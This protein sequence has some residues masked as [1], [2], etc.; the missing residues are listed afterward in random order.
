MVSHQWGWCFLL[1][2]VLVVVPSQ[3]VILGDLEV[4]LVDGVT[5]DLGRLQVRR[6]ATDAWGNVCRESFDDRDATVACRS[7][8]STFQWGR[9]MNMGVGGSSYPRSERIS[10]ASVSCVGTEANLGRCNTGRWRSLPA[11]CSTRY[12]AVHVRC[13]QYTARLKPQFGGYKGAIYGA[14]ELMRMGNNYGSYWYTLCDSSW[15][16][17]KARD[18]CRLAGFVD[19]KA[20]TAGQLSRGAVDSLQRTVSNLNCPDSATTANA[21]TFTTV[22]DTYCPTRGNMASAIC[23]SQASHMVGTGFAIRLTTGSPSLW[24]RVEV[25]HLGMWGTVCSNDDTVASVACR[26]VTG[27]GGGVVLGSTYGTDFKGSSW[28]SN[29]SCSGQESSL[30][31]CVVQPWGAPTSCRPMFSLCYQS[32]APTVELVGSSDGSYGRVEIVMDGSRYTVCGDHWTTAEASVVC[33]SKGYAG[34]VALKSSYY[35]KGSGLVALNNV[36]CNGSEDSLLQCHHNGWLKS[37]DRCDTHDKDVSVYCHGPVVLRGGDHSN[38][39]V[40]VMVGDSYRT[41]CG[42]NFQDTEAGVVCRQMGFE[43]GRKLPAGSYGPFTSRLPPQTLDC[44]GDENSAYNCSLTEQACASTGNT[45]YAAVHCY[46][47]T[48]PTA[49]T[50]SVSG[51]IGDLVNSSGNVRVQLAGVKGR[52]CSMFWGDEDARVMCRQLGFSKGLAYGLTTSSVGPF[53]LTEVN[54]V[55]TESS[56]WDC[57]MGNASCTSDSQASVLCFND[58]PQV[59]LVGGSSKEGRVEITYQGTTGTVCTQPGVYYQQAASVVCRTLGYAWGFPKSFGSGEGKVML[60]YPSCSGTESNLLGCRNL[61]FMAPPVEHCSDHKHDMGVHCRGEV[62]LSHV[63]QRTNTSMAGQIRLHRNGR[64]YFVCQT[65]FQEEE[66]AVVCSQ[67]GY[68]HY[69]SVPQGPL[70]AHTLSHS[71]QVRP[72][73]TGREQSLASCPMTFG[74]CYPTT[75]R[76]NVYANVHCSNEPIVTGVVAVHPTSQPGEV[77]VQVD[78]LQSKVCSQNW[79][80]NAAKLYCSALGYNFGKAMGALSGYNIF[81]LLSRISC[82]GKTSF[83][84]CYPTRNVSCDVFHKNARVYCYNDRTDFQIR[85]VGGAV[86]SEGIVEIGL[87][88]QWGSVC[89]SIIRYDWW[90][91]SRATN[92]ANIV[93]R[94]LGFVGGDAIR[95]STN[96]VDPVPTFIWLPRCTGRESDIRGCKL[97]AFNNTR[98]TNI[99]GCASRPV[100]VRCLG[101]VKLEPNATYGAVHMAVNISSSTF[102]LV[103][104]DGFGDEEATVTCRDL[105]LPYG[106]HLSASAFGPLSSPAIRRTNLQCSGREPELKDCNYG[107]SIHYCPSQKYASVVC[108]KSS[109]N[110]GYRV[111]VGTASNS[112]YGRVR[113]QHMDHWGSVCPDN[114]TAGDAAVICREAGFAGGLAYNYSSGW[115][116]GNSSG[117]HWLK[118]VGCMGQES[119]LTRC[120]RVQW[121]NITGCTFTNDAAVFCYQHVAPYFHLANGTRSGAGRLMVWTERGYGSVCGRTWTDREASVACRSLGFHGGR[122]LGHG[123]FGKATGDVLIPESSCSGDESSL[124]G[125]SLR[126]KGQHVQDTACLSHDYDAS[127]Q[128]YDKIQISGSR[129][130]RYGGVE[131]WSGASLGWVAVC[132]EGFDTNA[133]QV[134]CRALGYSQGRRQCCSALGPLTSPRNSMTATHIGAKVNRCSGSESTLTKCDI[135]FSNS[136]CSSGKYASVLCSDDSVEEIRLQVRPNWFGRIYSY[137]ARIEVNRYGVWGPVCNHGWDDRDANATCHGLGFNYGRSMFLAY[138]TYEPMLVGNF[139]CTGLESSLADCSFGGMDDDIGCFPSH[140]TVLIAEALCFNVS[141]DSSLR[142]EGGGRQYGRLEVQFQGLWGAVVVDLLHYY[143]QQNMHV[144]CKQ[145]GFQDGMSI[146]TQRHSPRI[147]SNITRT[148]MDLVGCNGTEKTLFDCWWNTRIDLSLF[149]PIN[150]VCYNNVRL[151]GGN[152]VSTGRVEVQVNNKWGTVCDSQW[153]DTN[154]RLTCRNMGF[155]DGIQ[156]CCGVYG[157]GSRPVLDSVQ[158]GNA[159]TN[160]TA[161]QH[162]RVGHF[163]C[164]DNTVAVSCFNGPRP[165]E[166]SYSIK[167]PSEVVINF[168]GLDGHICSDGWDD[169]DA[170]VLC[171]ELGYP[172]ALRHEHSA[173]NKP[174]WATNVNCQGNERRLQDCQMNLGRVTECRSGKW[175][176][177]LCT[178]SEG[179]YYQLGGSNTEGRGR[180]EVSIN[181]EW[182]SLCHSGFGSNEATVLCHSQGYRE[183]QVYTPPGGSYSNAPSTVYGTRQMMCSGDEASLDDCHHG[184]WRKYNSCKTEDVARVR[185]YNDVRIGGTYDHTFA[186]GAVQFYHNSTWYNLCDTGFDDTTARRVCQDLNFFDGVA[187]CCSGYGSTHY[188]TSAISTH[189]NYSMQCNGEEQSSAQCIKPGNCT[190]DM[191]ASVLCFGP[192]DYLDDSSECFFVFSLEDYMDEGTYTFALDSDK[193]YGVVAVTHMNIVGRVCNTDWDDTDA[194][195]FCKSRGYRGGIASHVSQQSYSTMVS[196]GPFWVSGFNC[197]GKEASLNECPFNDRRHLGNCSTADVA[198]ALCFITKSIQYRIASNGLKANEGRVEVSVAG[199]WGTVCSYYWDDQDARVFCRSQGYTDGFR[200][201]LPMNMG[202]GPMWLSNIRCKGTESSL[203]ECPHD[204]YRS[205]PVGI[206]HHK[207]CSTHTYDA[208]VHCVNKLKLSLRYTAGMGAVMVYRDNAWTL[209]CD[210]GLDHAA[211]QV[212]CKQLGFPFGTNLS[213]AKFGKVQNAS[214]SVSKVACRGTESDFST[215]TFDVTSGCSSGKYASVVCS[216][217]AQVEQRDNVRFVRDDSEDASHGYLEYQ[218]QGVWGAVCA[219]TMDP[220]AASVACRQLGY[221]GGVPYTPNLKNVRGT[222]HLQQPILTSNLK[223]NGTESRLDQCARASVPASASCDFNST[224]AGVLCYNDT[225]GVSYRLTGEETLKTRGRVEMKMNGQYSVVCTFYGNN[226][227]ARVACKSLGYKDG[228]AVPGARYLPDLSAP[229][230]LSKVTCQGNERSILECNSAGFNIHVYRDYTWYMCFHRTG[231]LSVQCYQD[232]VAITEVRLADGNAKGSGRVEV[233]LKGPNQWGTVCDTNWNDLS[234]TVVCN[235]LGFATGKAVMGAGFGEGKGKVWLNNVGCLGNETRLQDCGYNEYDVYGCLHKQDAGVI[236]SGVYVP[237]SSKDA[238]QKSSEHN[239]AAIVAPIVIILLVAC[240]GVYLGVYLR[241]RR[242]LFGAPQR[243]EN[244]PEPILSNDQLDIDQSGVVKFFN[245]V[246]GKKEEGLSNPCYMTQ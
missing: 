169:V 101:E 237:P 25:K 72:N 190:S 59:Q 162:E 173:V 22:S 175:A 56:L 180:V 52:F 167:S 203:H 43:H 46:N 189:N 184:G 160:L 48:L 109:P 235:Q 51:G 228:L 96:G 82:D 202:S 28:L 165:T 206:W 231:P 55:G 212:V 213:G 38:G 106:V 2:S 30:E 107:N 119:F 87:K 15:D 97:A 117:L 86:R 118:N 9:V 127:V 243:F 21:C 150:V 39:V 66:A 182:G 211:A 144:A 11:G 23:Y 178:N 74:P 214:I 40:E 207:P 186:Q 224:R 218:V 230:W 164:R 161:C 128:C 115:A 85:L 195:V 60:T 1:V 10:L 193:T 158:C 171:R 95:L 201:Y 209:V 116:E 145:L 4:R 71:W 121:G 16:D 132:D 7:L 208:H 8:G 222:W 219:S 181:G 148:W 140:D 14:V 225:E 29:V 240:L 32:A 79:D 36:Q 70:V 137:A 142:L 163:N 5:S 149:S 185:C 136:T 157:R 105:G 54:C 204:G 33:R 3:Q 12:G 120:P 238:N 67:L 61:G 114:F 31:Q 126:L 197:T 104:A 241:K 6:N 123:V 226:P 81:D 194:T 217:E 210:G 244:S 78:G 147:S 90:T 227:A 35:G 73:C 113:V 174:F 125:C 141:G 198:M 199:Q 17:S 196:Q 68:S 42:T 108:S 69:R 112:R 131:V 205:A 143:R 76:S 103:C 49:R 44:Q 166:F 170:K 84:S 242:S 152:G 27:R 138:S 216:K 80:D 155:D 221:S 13:Y 99:H 100:A 20:L 133:A 129:E 246:R 45:N 168:N 62:D 83:G 177:V 94:S 47:G 159:D 234:A 75:A 233:F 41:I 91:P 232:E 215:C 154:T 53:L 220:K 88:G 50:V 176:G 188:Q 187:V 102:G 179:I 65:Y 172:Y 26:Q 146:S 229:A 110:S 239:T 151:S 191:Y 34:G 64:N 98:K 236:C 77:L 19:G 130:V 92:E 89:D 245:R 37:T 57:P 122:Y 63:F 139:T 58:A 156:L 124:W 192:N 200:I 135:T 134:A 93:C 24:G 153:T 111:S 183:G 223:C 18:V